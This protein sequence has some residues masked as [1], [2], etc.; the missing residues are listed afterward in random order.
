MGAYLTTALNADPN[1][2]KYCINTAK[3][4]YIADTPIF[5]GIIFLVLN[6]LRSISLITMDG[7][8]WV[9]FREMR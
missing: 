2:V 9:L 1:P 4:V 3:M 7:V 5:L 6:H 8:K